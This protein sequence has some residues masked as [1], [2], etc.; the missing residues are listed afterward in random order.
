VTKGFSKGVQYAALGAVCFSFMSA[1]GKLAGDTIPTQQIVLVRGSVVTLWTYAL[2]RKQK[3][4]PWGTERGLLFLRGF[5]GYAA[6]SCF[7]WAVVR[8]P[9]ADTTVIHFT[10]PVFT[11]LLAAVFLGEVLRG[12]EVFLALVALAGVLIVARPGFLFGDVTGLEPM[13]VA[14]AMAGAILSAAAYVTAR[15]LTRTHDTLVIVFSFAFVSLVGSLPATLQVFV[16][17]TAWEWAVLLG[18]GVAAQGGQ[19]YVTK[20]LQVEKAGK[21]M[22]VG[23]LQIVFAAL[24]GVVMFGEIP[25]EWTAAGAAIIIGATFLMARVHPIATPHGR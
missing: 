13:A 7:L 24:W 14:A 4:S 9:L 25:D 20:A 23:Y 11:A 2:L 8:L 21:V 16:W 5:L 3:L 10:N 17:P 19:V 18:V 1:F 12:W 22:A 6:L 15:R